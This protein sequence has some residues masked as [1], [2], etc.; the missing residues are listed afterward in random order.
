MH[1]D[2]GSFSPASSDFTKCECCDGYA[3]NCDVTECSECGKLICPDC[4]MIV[5]GRNL[6]DSC[7][8]IAALDDESEDPENDPG[9]PMF[10]DPTKP[11]PRDWFY[12][13]EALREY[14]AQ[15]AEEER[16]K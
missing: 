13:Q 1:E 2:V 12:K 16:G 14:K 15:L 3:E 4:T 11:D 7:A 6:C 8:E 9:H 5:D 10:V